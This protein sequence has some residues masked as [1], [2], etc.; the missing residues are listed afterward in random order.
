VEGVDLELRRRLTKVSKRLSDEGLAPGISG[1]VSARIPETGTCLIKPSGVSLGAMKPEEFVVVDIETR[2]LLRGEVKPSIETPFHTTLYRLR[3]EVG[4]VVHVHPP[5]AITLSLI[6]EE[7]KPMT[8]EVFDAPGLASGITTSRYALPGSEELAEN[9]GEA[10]RLCVATLMP[11]HGVTALG[12]TPEEAATN[13]IVVERMASIQHK[14]MQVG[15]PEPL[16]D[17]TLKALV[18]LAKERGLLC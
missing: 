8:M 4:S 15:T 10:L 18:E 1:N 11:H 16:P 6:G 9:L 14:A 3:P 5:C 2:E 7:I 12:R 17:S 13:A